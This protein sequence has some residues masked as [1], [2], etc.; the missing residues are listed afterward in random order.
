M[1]LIDNLPIFMRKSKYIQNLLNVVETQLNNAD[2]SLQDIYNQLNIDTA[3]WGLAIY[4][5]ELGIT[6][7]VNKPLQE[8]R[9]YIK[10]KLRGIGKADAAKI[11]IVADA[12]TNGEV[13]VTFDGKINIKFNGEYGIPANIEDVEKAIEEVKAAHLAVVY[14]FAYLFI[15]D[16]EQLTIYEM[17][18]L[19]L[20]KFGGGN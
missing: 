6:T 1:S 9:E 17:E 19:T 11:K 8:R 18:Q 13:E 2:T 10:S 12:F 4:E 3:T 14:L 7:D 20:D 16:V 15:Y 5:K